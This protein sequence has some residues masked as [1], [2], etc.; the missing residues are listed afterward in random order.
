MRSFAYLFQYVQ[1]AYFATCGLGPA[2]WMFPAGST[3]L[4]RAAEA[5]Y[6]ELVQLL[7]QA[8][9]AVGSCDAPVVCLTVAMGLK[10]TL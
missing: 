4:F 6:E 10:V 5:G 2:A 8:G 3:A 7:I 9:A 1:F